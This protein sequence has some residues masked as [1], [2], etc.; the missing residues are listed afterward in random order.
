VT[1]RGRFAV[2]AAGVTALLAVLAVSVLTH[3]VG[4]PRTLAAFFGWDDAQ[5][6]RDRTATAEL[7]VQ[8]LVRDCMSSRGFPY[9]PFVESLPPPLGSNLDPVSWA[10]T[11]GFGVSI[12]TTLEVAGRTDPNLAFIA[13]LPSGAAQQ[14]RRALFGDHPVETVA[15][16]PQVDACLPLA[17]DEI[18]GKRNLLWPGKLTPEVATLQTDIRTD[19]RTRAA[20]DE[21]WRCVE[22]LG[23]VGETKQEAVHS[24]L[25]SLR[26]MVD[27]TLL[28]SQS[29]DQDL[30]DAIAPVQVEERRLATALAICDQQVASIVNAVTIEYEAQFIGDHRTALLSIREEL[31]KFDQDT[32]RIIDPAA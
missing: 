14:Y 8:V 28:Q 31:E 1:D 19:S 22:P 24:L 23:L 13:S 6:A 18:L 7:A 26:S 21:W 10:S 4:Q 17:T 3:E 16:E 15:N 27:R 5:A 20:D 2:L 32:R 9:V 25:A 30:A 29:G 12:P 11:Y